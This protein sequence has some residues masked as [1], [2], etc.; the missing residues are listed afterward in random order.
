M[1]DKIK[2]S[3]DAEYRIRVLD[4]AK[5]TKGEDVEKECS[6]FVTKITTFHEKVNDLVK[7]L[8]EHA[9]RIDSQKLRVCNLSTC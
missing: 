2:I 5:F 1:D 7:V 3:F 4:P 9:D 6:S 8:E